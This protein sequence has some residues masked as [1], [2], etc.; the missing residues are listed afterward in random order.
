MNLSQKQNKSDW[1]YEFRPIL[2]FFFGF[3]GI[4]NSAAAGDFS[5]LRISQFCGAVLIFW[6]LK[7]C[8]W[9]YEYR[10]QRSGFR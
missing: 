5:L 1:F 2:I 7:I 9:R 3:L 4:F 6:G 10:K 8:H